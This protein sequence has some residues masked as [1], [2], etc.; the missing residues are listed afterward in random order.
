VDLR[1]FNLDHVGILHFSLSNKGLGILVTPPNRHLLRAQVTAARLS[2]KH[3]IA[4][5]EV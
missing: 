5:D 1:Q 4:N 3:P 2:L